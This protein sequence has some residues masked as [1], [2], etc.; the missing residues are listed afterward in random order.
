MSNTCW[1]KNFPH[2]SMVIFI[3]GIKTLSFCGFHYEFKIG[4]KGFLRIIFNHFNPMSLGKTNI[5]VSRVG[6]GTGM[7]GGNRQSNQTRL[8][9]ENFEAL[10][11]A[12]YERG[13]RLFDLADLYGT[14]PYVARALRKMPRKD[15]VISSKIWWRRG[16]IPEKQRPDA[17]IV[18]Q[19]FLN[20][21]NTDYI[22]IILLHC[23]DRPNWPDELGEQMNI[24]E[25]LK[26]KGIVR[27]HGVSCHSLPALQAAA[28]EPWVD[29]VNVRINAYGKNMDGPVAKVEPVV[30]K[31]HK[32]GK[33]VIGMKLIGEGAFRNSDE[34]RDNSIH[35]VLGLGCVDAMVVGFEKLEEIDDFA[36]RVRKVSTALIKK[37]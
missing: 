9:K 11:R 3:M 30:R 25:K 24:L 10:L 17:D 28:D 2:L 18:V 1:L 4:F 21:L 8:G 33:G 22:D 37:A 23:V 34:K 14:H 5:K 19:R 16:G 32:A 36:A 20:E 7:R 15:Y 12:S 13:V 27:A 35:Y 6:F 29:S 31:L 26:K